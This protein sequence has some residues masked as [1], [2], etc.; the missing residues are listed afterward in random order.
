MLNIVLIKA[1]LEQL[2]E[3]T[4]SSTSILPTY[5][6][7][8]VNYKLVKKWEIE[9]NTLLIENNLIINKKNKIV[10]NNW[11]QLMLGYEQ[12]KQRLKQNLIE[13]IKEVQNAK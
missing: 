4:F 13:N 7:K 1:I 3:D 6:I 2:L 9:I 8:N 10:V 12:L 11:V 5:T